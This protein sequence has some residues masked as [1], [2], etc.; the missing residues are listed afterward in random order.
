MSSDSFMASAPQNDDHD[1]QKCGHDGVQHHSPLAL[2]IAALEK[3]R[4]SSC[5]M[6]PSR[7]SRSAMV[8]ARR[9]WSGMVIEQTC[10]GYLPAPR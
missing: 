6:H 2:A 9:W 8:I 7:Y 5:D 4:A 1:T 10:N 3:A